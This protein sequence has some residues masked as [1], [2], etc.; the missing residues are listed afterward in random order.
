MTMTA[1]ANYERKMAH[2]FAED[3]K[4]AE[5]SHKL[6]M[7]KIYAGNNGADERVANKRRARIA[8]EQAQVRPNSFQTGVQ[9]GGWL[10]RVVV[11]TNPLDPVDMADEIC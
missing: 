10:L 4:R 3:V 2:T 11:A 6:H 5:F 1:R 7:D 8:G 9:T